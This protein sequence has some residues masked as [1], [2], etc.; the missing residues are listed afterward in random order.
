VTGMIAYH[1]WQTIMYS[2]RHQYESPFITNLS[3]A[4]SGRSPLTL[5][6]QRQL[7]GGADVYKGRLPREEVIAISKRIEA[8]NNN[9]FGNIDQTW[10]TH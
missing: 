9:Q 5:A 10:E 1:T 2:H 4:L 8:N 7:P 3:P 6:I